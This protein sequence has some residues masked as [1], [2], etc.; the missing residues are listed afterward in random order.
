MRHMHDYLK[1]AC[2]ELPL[3]LSY[4]TAL[5]FIRYSEVPPSSQVKIESSK[6]VRTTW[7]KIGSSCS[8]KGGTCTVPV[9]G[10]SRENLFVR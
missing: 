2:A 10:M 3:S 8:G 4:R 7:L 6:G 9:L 5:V 1:Q